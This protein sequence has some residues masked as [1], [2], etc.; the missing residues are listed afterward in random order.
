MNHKSSAVKRLMKELQDLNDDPSPEYTASPLEDNIFEWHFTLRGPN[1]AGFSGGR[2]H[3]RLIFPPEYPFKPPNISFLTPNGRF[4]VGKKICLS[5]TGHHPEFWLP[6]WGIRLALIALISFMPTQG[7]GAIGALDHTEEERAVLARQSRHW[8]CEICGSRNSDALPDE[9][10]RPVEPMAPSGDIVFSIKGDSPSTPTQNPP[11]PAEAASD[12]SV[13]SDSTEPSA[14]VAPLAATAGMPADSTGSSNPST[15]SPQPNQVDSGPR[16]RHI[17]AQTDRNPAVPP[18]GTSPSPAALAQHRQQ[19]RETLA[20][21]R[22]VETVLAAVLFV[23]GLLILK[24]VM[25]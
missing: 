1:E 10:E 12:P 7:D 19:I 6:A 9:T 23:V 11:A 14:S 8:K 25:F 24:K 5:I 21:R 22:Q 3:G 16:H 15:A 4:E 17:P 2:Y 13:G 20:L 18:T